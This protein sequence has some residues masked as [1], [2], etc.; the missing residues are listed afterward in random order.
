[1]KRDDS[2]LSRLTPT[3]SQVPVPVGAGWCSRPVHAAFTHEGRS[4]LIRTAACGSSMEL[5]CPNCNGTELKRVTLVYQEGLSHLKTRSLWWGWVFGEGGPGVAAG[6][7]VTR[8][9]QQTELSRTV[10]P[11]VKRSY[12]RLIFRSVTVTFLAAGAYIVFVAASTPPVSTLPL[13]IYVFVA[14]VVFVAL[15]F[16]AWRHNHLVYPMK[17]TEWDRS[18]LCQRCGA[19]S[20]Q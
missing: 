19:V 12:R 4:S 14:P 1:M 6:R 20:Q 9:A 11:P 13:R 8:G 5:R 2:G 15:A 7:A 17:C 18:F 16:A 10:K 3:R